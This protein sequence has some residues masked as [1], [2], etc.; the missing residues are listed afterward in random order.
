MDENIARLLFAAA[1]FVLAAMA[2]VVFVWRDRRPRPDTWQSIVRTT[3][4]RRDHRRSFEH[5]HFD[6]REHEDES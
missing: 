3:P 4:P 1:G 6:V 2:M 5:R